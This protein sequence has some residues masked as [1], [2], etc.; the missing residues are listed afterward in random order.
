MTKLIRF[1]L[2]EPELSYKIVGIL[3]D[4]SNAIGYGHREVVYCRA[5]AQAFTVAGIKFAE[6]VACNIIY[7]DKIVG[8]H[9]L[10]FLVE[11]KIVL[12]IKRGD[13]FV[14]N[15]F[16]QVISYLQT[17]HLSLA[18]LANFTSQGVTFKRVLNPDLQIAISNS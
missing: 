4:V 2:I 13:R 1:D 3:Y 18:I 9:V 16:N 8:K 5:I 11:D 17:A 12:E 6:Q 15:N 14:K 7:K 10:D